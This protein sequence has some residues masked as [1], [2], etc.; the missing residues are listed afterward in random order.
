M[1]FVIAITFGL[2]VVALTT[3]L[4]VLTF[5]R[6][7]PVPQLKNA[8]KVSLLIPARNEAVV[9]GRTVS[10]LLAQSYTNFEVIVLDDHSQDGTGELARE[11]AKGDARLRVLEGEPLPEGWLGKNWACQQLSQAAT[12]EWLIFTDADVNW[13]PQALNSLVTTAVR[14]QADMLT[15]WPTQETITWPERLV[16]S[17]MALAIVGYLPV[18]AVNHT[19]WTPFAAANGQCL[20][21]RRKIYREIGEHRIARNQIV[22]DVYLARR[23]KAKGYKL[24]MVDGQSQVRCR[25]YHD[26]KT[27]R[28]GFAKNILAGHGNSL[29]FLALSTVFHWSLF[30]FPWLWLIAA[31]VTGHPLIWPLMLVALGVGVRALTAAMTQQRIGD[32]LFMP[33]S[34]FLMTLIAWRSVWWHIR[35]GGPVWKDRTINSSNKVAH[36]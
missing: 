19:S 25:M 24:Y 20:M 7:R 17:L 32:A 22:E 15:V 3:I 8:P 1:A 2:L 36:G 34:V 6:L 30:V 35:L 5:P 16:V 27:V 9:I 26:W 11:A 12:G 13:S 29:I 33:V 23:T 18:V 14:S 10:T 31:L 21:F 4:N 28:D